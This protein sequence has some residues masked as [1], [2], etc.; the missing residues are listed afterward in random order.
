MT[1]TKHKSRLKFSIIERGGN[2]RIL[3]RK[4]YNFAKTDDASSLIHSAVNIINALTKLLRDLNYDQ[5]LITV[6]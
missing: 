2:S 4:K 1:I 3:E 5:R 6:M